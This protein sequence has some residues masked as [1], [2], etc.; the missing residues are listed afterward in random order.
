MKRFKM[1]TLVVS[2]VVLPCLVFAASHKVAVGDAVVS[3]TE[4]TVTVP[5]EIAN[6]DDFVAAD[7]PLRFSEGVTLDKVSFK[8]TRVENFDLT[9]AN[10]DNK[11]KTVVIGLVN[12]LSA[13]RKAA[14]TNG[15]G[16]V[17]YLTFTIDDPSLTE[18]VLEP[19]VMENPRHEMMFIYNEITDNGPVGPR[20]EDPVFENLAFSLTGDTDSELPTEYALSQ[21]YPNPFNPT[22]QISFSLPTPGNVSLEVYN[23]LGQK[24]TTLVDGN[25][26]AGNH[27][28]EWDGKNS[29]GVGV[30]SGVYF[31]R[32]AT[33][34]FV[35]TKKMM[36]L[37]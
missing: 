10:I 13:E 17:A 5:L 37:K 4:R 15:E 19:T 16:P 14:L 28:V 36:M 29:A 24:V 3:N 21:N 33:D 27:V 32:I 7:I 1:L 25:M 26:G 9:V 11:E 2:V 22:T 30:S 6:Q 31:Y 18:V 12:Q 20:T 35:D 8:D 23:V 34:N